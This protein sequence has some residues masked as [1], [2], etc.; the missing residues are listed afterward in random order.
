[1]MDKPVLEQQDLDKGLKRSAGKLASCVSKGEEDSNTLLLPNKYKSSGKIALQQIQENG[2]Y[3]PYLL[4][5]KA[6]I[7]LG[8]NFNE[9]TRMVDNWAYDIQEAHLK[10]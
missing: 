7:L 6:I 2:Y 3:K 5:Q 9:S 4:R 8:L 10:K 1:M